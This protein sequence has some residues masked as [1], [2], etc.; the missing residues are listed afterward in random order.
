[1]YQA[2]FFPLSLAEEGRQSAFSWRG[3]PPGYLDNYYQQLPLFNPLWG[4]WDS[5]HIPIEIIRNRLVDQ[6][7]LRYHLVPLK[8]QEGLKPITRLTFAQDIQF[9]LS[10]LDVGLSFYYRPKSYLKISANNFLRDGSSGAF[11]EIKV[12]TY[13]VHVHQNL[14]DKFNLDLHY[15]Q[16]RHDFALSS[17][18]VVTE[19]HDYNRVGHL[20]WSNLNYQPDSLQKIT[21]TPYLY[22]WIE[23]YHTLNDIQKRRSDQYSAGLKGNYQKNYAQIT[24]KAEGN[25]VRHDISKATSFSSEGHLEGQVRGIV[26]IRRGNSWLEG[27][28]GYHYTSYAGGNPELFLGWNWSPFTRFSSKAS[29]YQK[30]QRIPVGPMNWQGFGISSLRDP[31]L[32][33]RRGISWQLQLKDISG[34]NFQFE[35]YYNQFSNAQSYRPA[36]STFIQEDF[37]NPGFIAGLD[38]NLWIFEMQN[39]LSYNLNYDRV[40]IPRVKNVLTVN[41]PFSILKGA[42]KMDNYIIY[43]YIGPVQKFDYY[44]LVNQ[45]TITSQEAGNYHIVDAKILAHIKTAT[46]YFIW[47]N[48]VSQDYA[49]VD[50]YFEIYRLFRFGIYWTLYD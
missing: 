5:Q 9:G 28:A 30:P 2:D 21:L 33:A 8:M 38:K 39:A 20:L 3:M 31:V 43:Q 32:P 45:Y 18:P 17:F 14:T 49:I 7:N 35:P 29:L 37:D 27:G 41:I 11:S 47:E 25:V 48:L 19:V 23:H 44:P 34:W 6:P 16:I 46:I 13:R 50:S 1:M 4:Y 22:R 26:Q 40:F 36:D 15:W 10:Y 42:L 24:L 12:N